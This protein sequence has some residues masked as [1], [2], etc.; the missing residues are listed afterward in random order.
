ML[1][2]T[3]VARPGSFVPRRARF[4][5]AGLAAALLVLGAL[6]MTHDLRGSLSFALELRGKKLAAMVLVGTG[7]GTSAVLFHTVTANRILTPSLM[8]FDQ[9]YVLIQT[10]AA[11]SLGTFAYLSVDER[12]RFGA[13]VA[14]LVGFA[15]VLHSAFLRRAAHDLPL[16]V[17]AGVVLGSMFASLSNLVARLIDPNEYTTLQDQFFASFATVAED[18]L[19]VSGVATAVCVA[20]AWRMTDALDVVALGHDVATAL[21]VVHRTVVVRTLVLVAVLVAVPTA[22]VGPITF[23]GLLVANLAYRLT[24][25]FRHRHTIPA[26]ALGGA[27]ALVGAQFVLEELFAFRTRSSIIISVVGGVTFLVL[28]LREAAR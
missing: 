18:L 8:G 1:A 26:A 28:L 23:L 27:V 21:G 12:V 11:W 5:I 4:V 7:L 3:G 10:T 22:L 20:I 24:A 15:L 17:L 9:L 25:T 13:Q 19:V 6:F 14:V 16:L 2:E